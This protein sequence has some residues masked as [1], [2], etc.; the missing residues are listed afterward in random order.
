MTPPDALQGQVLANVAAGDGI[1]NA[2]VLAQ[3]G[4]Y[5]QGAAFDFAQAFQAKGGTVSSVIP[6]DPGSA[7]PTVISATLAT[8]PGAIVLFGDDAPVGAIITALST[9]GRGPDQ[10][11]Y[12]MGNISN[13]LP[14]FVS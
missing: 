1:T 14:Q 10:V 11:P 5:G 8:N 7:D 6:F 4:T 3:K 9:A 2:V 13:S 12:F